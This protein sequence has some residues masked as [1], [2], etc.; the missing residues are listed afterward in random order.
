M[1]N[2]NS[3]HTFNF[4]RTIIE[5]H[6]RYYLDGKMEN[7]KVLV[8]IQKRLVE[9][10]FP[11]ISRHIHRNKIVDP[12]VVFSNWILG[13]FNFNTQSESEELKGSSVCSLDQM[14]QSLLPID[15]SSKNIFP[16]VPSKVKSNNQ[17]SPKYFD[18]M[19]DIFVAEGW[20]GFFKCSLVM[21]KYYEVNLL[22]WNGSDLMLKLSNF[23]QFVF[24][25]L[26]KQMKQKFMNNKIV[27]L[28]NEGGFGFTPRHSVI[29]SNP[30]DPSL[31]LLSSKNDNTYSQTDT[32]VNSIF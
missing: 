25:D 10:F 27:G 17:F 4:V 31:N 6:L 1:F 16:N 5:Q 14:E 7:M 29:F 12:L 8:F 22:S 23:P 32:M 21:L 19:M 13:L 11:R 28:P 2:G 24:N 26:E 15:P 20:A 9:I 30:K 18:Q 3:L